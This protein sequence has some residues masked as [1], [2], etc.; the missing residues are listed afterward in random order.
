MSKVR[1]LLMPMVFLL[2]VVFGFAPAISQPQSV[3]HWMTP[4]LMVLRMGPFLKGPQGQFHQQDSTGGEALSGAECRQGGQQ[5][6]IGTVLSQGSPANN[7]YHTWGRSGGPAKLTKKGNRVDFSFQN[8]GSC[9]AFWRQQCWVSILRCGPAV[10]Q[11]VAG[12]REEKLRAGLGFG[13]TPRIEQRNFS[14]SLQGGG[15]GS[16]PGGSPDCRPDALSERPP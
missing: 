5:E 8:K 16:I 2:S 10:G 6:V 7:I 12:K 4:N 1:A 3:R 14:L 9:G 13:A 15:W 11:E